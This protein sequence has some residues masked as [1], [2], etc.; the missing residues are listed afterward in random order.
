MAQRHY[1]K[2][3]ARTEAVESIFLGLGGSYWTVAAHL[4]RRSRRGLE[5]GVK[6]NHGAEGR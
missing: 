3:D 6:V 1:T 5:C 2:V 4:S